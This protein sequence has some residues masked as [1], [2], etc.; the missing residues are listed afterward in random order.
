MTDVESRT[1]IGADSPGCERTYAELRVYP[2]ALSPADV[3]VML[4]IE[5]TSTQVAGEVRTNSL[6]RSRA[7]PR[8]GWFLS[9]EDQ[10]RPGDLRCHLD[11]LLGRLWP[12]KENLA[13][14]RRA[15]EM[16]IAVACVW[17]A[18][19]EG[20]GPSLGPEQMRLLG[21]LGLE[22]QFDVAFFGDENT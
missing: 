20:V 4:G 14:M 21:E 7:V 22:C 9:S 18:S 13:G 8:N 16:T 2:E 17:W 3:T 11:W 15:H 1:P 5:P 10:V 6:G 19:G 12:V